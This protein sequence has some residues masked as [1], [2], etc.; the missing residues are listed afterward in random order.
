M[1]GGTVGAQGA[2][3][4]AGAG[5][6]SV[7][8]MLTWGGGR[9]HPGAFRLTET[10]FIRVFL[11]VTNDEFPGLLFGFEMMVDG[12]CNYQRPGL[13]LV[14]VDPGNSSF[15]SHHHIV[16][17]GGTLGLMDD[18]LGLGRLGGAIRGVIAWILLA[19]P[20]SLSLLGRL[21]LPIAPGGSL[22]GWRGFRFPLRMGG[23]L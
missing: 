10:A 14:L 23:F 2:V 15:S 13:A 6:G 17:S 18:D 3:A 22:M 16:P 11:E 5:M 4:G 20:G 1:G 12:S 9:S 8:G 7:I 19:L 21:L